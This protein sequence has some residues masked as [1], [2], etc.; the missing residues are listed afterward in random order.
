[1]L[2]LIL[3]VLLCEGGWCRCVVNGTPYAFYSTLKL[4][5]QKQRN[6]D[7]KHT[8]HLLPLPSPPPPP[9]RAVFLCAFRSLC[10]YAR[11]PF[12]CSRISSLCVCARVPFVCSR[13]S[14]LCVCARVPFVYEPS[15]H[16]KFCVFCCVKVDGV[17]ALGNVALRMPIIANSKSNHIGAQC[18]FAPI[19]MAACY[20]NFDSVCFVV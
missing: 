20:V 10:V 6:K 11:V 14:S 13:I 18:I 7:H 19:A 8:R 1:M 12:V 15:V 2:I 3:C 9:H 4:E 16:F 17:A 5:S